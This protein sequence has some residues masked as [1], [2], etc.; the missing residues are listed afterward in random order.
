MVKQRIDQRPVEIAGGRVDDEAGRLVDD[1][2]MLVL[3]DDRQRDVLRLIVRRFG[4]RNRDAKAR[5]RAP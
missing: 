2:Q 4:L 1:Q 3:E 5:R